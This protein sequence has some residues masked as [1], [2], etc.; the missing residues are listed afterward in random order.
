M[1]FLLMMAIGWSGSVALAAPTT[2]HHQARLT[3]AFGEPINSEVDVTF[4]LWTLESGGLNPFTE[5]LTV[6]PVEG[7]SAS[8]W[9]QMR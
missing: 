8:T 6:T 5:T 3:D 2:V 1:R 7:S 4:E 9:A